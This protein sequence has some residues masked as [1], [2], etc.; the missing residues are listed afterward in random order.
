[1]AE[2]HREHS[3]LSASLY[4]S[5]PLSMAR[6]GQR[7]TQTTTDNSTTV[8][9]TTT[10]T[11]TRKQWQQKTITTITAAAATA[12]TTIRCKNAITVCMH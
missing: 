8:T 12:T 6:T 11:T 4:H 9:K 2:Y 1:M 7:S 3:V 10:T 5:R